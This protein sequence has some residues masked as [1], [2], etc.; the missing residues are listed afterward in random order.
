MGFAHRIQNV[1]NPIKDDKTNS[2]FSFAP[3]V[4]FSHR[5][6]VWRYAALKFVANRRTGKDV[7]PLAKS[8]RAGAPMCEITALR[9]RATARGYVLT[10]QSPDKPW[11]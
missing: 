11:F 7:Q 9:A 6:L 4:R 2:V 3:V 10:H 8:A 1:R 5:R